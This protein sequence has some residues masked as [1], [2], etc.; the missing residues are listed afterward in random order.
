MAKAATPARGSK[1][2]EIVRLAKRPNG[3][4]GAEIIEATG[5][6]SGSGSAKWRVQHLAIAR[7]MKAVEVTRR[8]GVVAWRLESATKAPAKKAAAA[9]TKK[10]PRRAPQPA[11]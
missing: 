5:W 1:T 9:A 8:D 4:T 7:E 2:E 11:A 10:A 3:V 6:P